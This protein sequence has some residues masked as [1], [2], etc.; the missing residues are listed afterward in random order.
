MAVSRTYS[1]SLALFLVVALNASARELHTEEFDRTPLHPAWTFFAPGGGS[2]KIRGGWLH[3]T[4]PGLLWPFAVDD[5]SMSPMLLVE[6]PEGEVFTFETRLKFRKHVH[7]STAG[8][9]AIGKDLE[10]RMVMSY[11]PTPTGGNVT[12][13]WR[14][15]LGDLNIEFVGNALA[16][17]PGG[18]T[19]L[20]V[21]FPSDIPFS[22]PKFF[23][24]RGHEG[25]PWIDA[26]GPDILFPFGL[27]GRIKPRFRPGEYR[28]GLFV[29]GGADRADDE[30]EVAF[31]YFHSPE[32]QT[33]AVETANTAT[34]T[35]ASLKRR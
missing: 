20:R 8:L 16:G 12:L 23:F 30:E 15:G 26:A 35:W 28:I 19:W 29:S 11:L 10:S 2:Y 14:D 6:P 18:H 17:P 32:L 13:G 7:F 24:K 5:V 3:V 9:V 22:Q 31:D 1:A 33:L 27:P 25:D 34:T 4:S 21:E